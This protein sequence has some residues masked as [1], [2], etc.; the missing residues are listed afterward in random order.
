MF[1]FNSS[2]RPYTN[3]LSR[4]VS[5]TVWSARR[6][7]SSWPST[8]RYVFTHQINQHTELLANNHP[9][10]SSKRDDCECRAS[11]KEMK[12]HTKNVGKVAMPKFDPLSG[13]DGP[14]VEIWKLAVIQEN[15]A[16]SWF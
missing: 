7:T 13:K 5:A 1:P 4:Q 11:P 8:P 12:S 6:T 10:K 16:S 15:I 2:P 14:L 9:Q 3:S